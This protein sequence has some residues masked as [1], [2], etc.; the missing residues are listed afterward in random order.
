[1]NRET[2]AS[3]P[4][5]A[6]GR[7]PEGRGLAS[8]AET[9]RAFCSIWTY[10]SPSPF[11][12]R[13]LLYRKARGT[14]S[15][16]AGGRPQPQACAKDSVPQT[17]HPPGRQDEPQSGDVLSPPLQRQLW[18]STSTVPDPRM[19]RGFCWVPEHLAGP[20]P[21][22]RLASTHCRRYFSTQG[23]GPHTCGALAGVPCPPPAL[24]P[25]QGRARTLRH[26]HGLAIHTALL[27][28][29]RKA[30][31]WGT[32]TWHLVGPVVVTVGAVWLRAGLEVLGHTR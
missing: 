3:L 4:N 23:P 29:R 17:V 16:G 30:S 6:G 25:P 15:D 22:S 27:Q 13:R 7:S 11:R 5:G 18:G 14:V 9:A 1:M 2:D 8:A 32:Q 20:M 24:V 10:R 21:A 19:S 31:G 28:A 26:T 12:G